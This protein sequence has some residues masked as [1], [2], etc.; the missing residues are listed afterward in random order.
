MK[1]MQTR[2]MFLFLSALVLIPVN[3][4]ADD[5]APLTDGS[6]LS[7]YSVVNRTSLDGNALSAPQG[8]VGVNMAAGDNNAQVNARAIIIGADT[9]AISNI[10]IRQNVENGS[11]ELL[12]SY[13]SDHIG[14]EAFS[15]SKGIASVNQTAGNGNAQG[16]LVAI[17]IGTSDVAAVSGE[18]LLAYHANLESGPQE[19]GGR[20]SDIIDGRAFAGSQGLVQVNQSAGSSNRVVNTLAV[21][22]NLVNVP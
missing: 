2:L 22:F 15:A 1:N 7:D 11:S 17:G 21:Q 16:N 12:P 10:N 13:H 5:S 20:R 14:G 8:V 3:G 9:R 4:M 6:S 19:Y 18:Q